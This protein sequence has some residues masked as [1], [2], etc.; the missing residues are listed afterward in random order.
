MYRPS[1]LRHSESAKR[2][3]RPSR[4]AQRTAGSIER[5]TPGAQRPNGGG[6]TATVYFSGAGVIRSLN[7]LMNSIDKSHWCL[8]RTHPMTPDSRRLFY[9]RVR[10]PF[11]LSSPP[12]DCFKHGQ[13]VA[14][15][16]L[17]RL[18]FRL[19]DG[20]SSFCLLVVLPLPVFN[21]TANP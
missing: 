20:F 1:W 19:P 17:T 8:V 10:R 18:V 7:L 15:P 21:E 4:R 3:Q 11:L 2:A 14:E 5:K 13:I 16:C 6:H 9:R 12:I